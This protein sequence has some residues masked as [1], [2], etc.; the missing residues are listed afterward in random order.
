MTNSRTD[1]EPRESPTD[2]APGTAPDGG[3]SSDA[4]AAKT[5][6]QTT[7]TEPVFESDP[8]ATTGDTTGE[9]RYGADDSRI[10]S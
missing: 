10:R 7:D 6:T 9:D 1:P 8:G 5:D 3:D 4:S 2:Y